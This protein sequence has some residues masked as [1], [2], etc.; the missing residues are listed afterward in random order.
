MTE[1]DPR[2]GVIP[3]RSVKRVPH[4]VLV[5]AQ[6]DGQGDETMTVVPLVDGQRIAGLEVRCRCGSAVVVELVTEA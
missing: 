2:G 1:S 6:A 5:D 3:A 4:A